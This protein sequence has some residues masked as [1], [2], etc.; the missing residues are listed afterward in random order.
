MESPFS[1]IILWRCQKSR[2]LVIYLYRSLSRCTLSR[3]LSLL[4]VLLSLLVIQLLL[5][6]KENGGCRLEVATLMAG[7]SCC[8]GTL[9][10]QVV[11][12]GLV[13]FYIFR[14]CFNILPS[15]H[16]HHR[17][18]NIG[19]TQKKARTTTKKSSAARFKNRILLS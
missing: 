9:C 7:C 17:N 19:L 18:N 2:S 14:L 12:I 6:P 4:L 13:G 8:R 5:L 1:I 3:S 16:H 10:G 15:Q 11:R